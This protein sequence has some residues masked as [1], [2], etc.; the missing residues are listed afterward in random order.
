MHPPGP[1]LLHPECNYALDLFWQNYHEQDKKAVLEGMAAGVA[2][3][4]PDEI[5]SEDDEDDRY[6]I[7]QIEAGLDLPPECGTLNIKGVIETPPEWGA[8]D[9]G[10]P[11]QPR[12][13]PEYQPPQVC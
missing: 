7:T 5:D 9:E 12:R 6:E 3:G 10:N 2:D 8:P 1:S 13:P 11:N 4:L